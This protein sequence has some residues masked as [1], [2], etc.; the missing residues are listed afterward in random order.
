MDFTKIFP[1]FW[2][3]IKGSNTI[4]NIIWSYICIKSVSTNRLIISN[5]IQQIEKKISSG[6]VNVFY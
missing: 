2:L 3:Q 4:N 5:L 1:N 6:L